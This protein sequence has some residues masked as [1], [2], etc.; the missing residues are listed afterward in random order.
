MYYNARRNCDIEI[1]GESEIE[2]HI[3]NRKVAATVFKQTYDFR[4]QLD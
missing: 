2:G 4:L 3:F 1:V